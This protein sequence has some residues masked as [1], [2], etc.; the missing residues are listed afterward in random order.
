ME[1]LAWKSLAVPFPP[2]M[3]LLLAALP[4]FLLVQ[5][6]AAQP[7]GGGRTC[8]I[9]LKLLCWQSEGQPRG[10]YD[11]AHEHA[12]ALQAAKC[13]RHEIQEFCGGGR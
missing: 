11:C 3:Q 1:V 2:A 9:D 12:R 4:L 10:C 13:Q 7:G 8:G 6:A 5:S